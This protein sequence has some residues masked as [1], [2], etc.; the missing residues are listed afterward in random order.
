VEGSRA[1]Y[2]PKAMLRVAGEVMYLDVAGQPAVV[3]NSL[4]SAFEVLERRAS[5]Y[6]DLCEGF[7]R[8][9]GACDASSYS[10]TSA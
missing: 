5:N 4:K 1:D 8:G 3:C 9:G 10:K 6:S 2:I 7:V